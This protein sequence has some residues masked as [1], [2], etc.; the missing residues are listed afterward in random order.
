MGRMVAVL[1][2]IR[3]IERTDVMVLVTWSVFGRD[4][5]LKNLRCVL[6]LTE[7]NFPRGTTTKSDKS[8]T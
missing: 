7:P 2:I 8:P 1:F 6:I 3:M 4:L 5:R